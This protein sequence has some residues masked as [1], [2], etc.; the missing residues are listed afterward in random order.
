MKQTRTQ[1]RQ[2]ILRQLS[3][4]LSATWRENPHA[5]KA[6][7]RFV[8][9]VFWGP[10]LAMVIAV[11]APKTV[12]PLMPFFVAAVL[13]L[14]YGPAICS[15]RGLRDFYKLATDQD[16]HLHNEMNPIKVALIVSFLAPICFLFR[17]IYGNAYFGNDRDEVLEHQQ[18]SPRGSSKAANCPTGTRDS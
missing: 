8:L 12:S 3:K 5:R 4:V 1:T 14:W 9:S 15:L 16:T 7:A 13:V 11:I 10:A 17:T 18:P 6:L 2:E